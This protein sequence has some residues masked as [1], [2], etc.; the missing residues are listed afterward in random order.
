MRLVLRG[1]LTVFIALLLPALAIAAIVIG[2]Q[3]TDRYRQL[4]NTGPRH[5]A[6][7]V[8]VINPFKGPNEYVVETDGKRFTL[9]HGEAVD[10]LDPKPGDSIEYVIDTVDPWWTVGVGD[11]AYWEP[12]PVTGTIVAVLI[13]GVT[14]IFALFA[15]EWLLPAGFEWSGK[16]RTRNTKG[17]HADES[18]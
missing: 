12:H 13:V 2:A 6:T 3:T 14:L 16:R 4:V 9:D 18:Q 17:K 10:G 11:P 1:I 5:I 15:V 8:K 7:L